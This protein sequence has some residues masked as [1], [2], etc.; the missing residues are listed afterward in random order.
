MVFED[1]WEI[2]KVGL[3]CG[4]LMIHHN[5]QFDILPMIDLAFA[6]LPSQDALDFFTKLFDMGYGYYL[7]EKYEKLGYDL[8]IKLDLFDEWTSKSHK[9]EFK[10]LIVDSFRV[11]FLLDL[12][13]AFNML[14]L[15]IVAN[16][17]EV[18]EESTSGL[19]AQ[20]TRRESNV[21]TSRNFKNLSLIHI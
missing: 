16:E 15:L 12:E 2:S 11:M 13:N 10:D 20:D 4:V 14:K 7:L 21:P 9:T 3:H 8:L 6:K 18:Q 5:V 19:S 17:R 1:M